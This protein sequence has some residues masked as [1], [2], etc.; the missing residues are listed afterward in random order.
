MEGDLGVVREE[1]RFF[2]DFLSES[3]RKRDERIFKKNSE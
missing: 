3:M 1:E 2:R